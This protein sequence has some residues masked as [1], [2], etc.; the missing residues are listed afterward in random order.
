MEQTRLVLLSAKSAKDFVWN[1]L[2]LEQS[3]ACKVSL[4]LWKWWDVRNKVNGGDPIQNIH[5]GFIIRDYTGEHVLAGAG[6]A[7]Q[8]HDALMAE[9][10][11]CLKALETAELYGISHVQLDVDSSVLKEAITCDAY[12]RAPCGVFFTD[13]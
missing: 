10:V 8:L 4:L 2:Q 1:V 7:G 3:L 13:I 6:N 9:A 12:D 11:S 5:N